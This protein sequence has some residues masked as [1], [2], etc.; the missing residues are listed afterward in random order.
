MLF[1]GI[2]YN[3]DKA[4]KEDTVEADSPE[5]ATVK[6]M[7]MYPESERPAEFISVLPKEEYS[8]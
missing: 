4:V 7:M 6:F 2:W 3:L 5:D 8:A 1:K